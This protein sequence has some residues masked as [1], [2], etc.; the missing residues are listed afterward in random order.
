MVRIFDKLR[1]RP[2]DAASL[3]R[4]FFETVITGFLT[5]MTAEAEP[6]VLLPVKAGGCCSRYSARPEYRDD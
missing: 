4:R 1:K 2:R 6:A 5:E 3:K